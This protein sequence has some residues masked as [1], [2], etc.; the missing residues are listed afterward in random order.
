LGGGHANHTVKC[1]TQTPSYQNK[2]TKHK[3]GSKQTLEPFKIKNYVGVILRLFP[4]EPYQA[5]L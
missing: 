5:S 2:A 3:K 4:S 1:P